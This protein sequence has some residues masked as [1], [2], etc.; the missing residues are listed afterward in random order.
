LIHVGNLKAAKMLNTA[1]LDERSFACSKLR[2]SPDRNFA[3]LFIDNIFSP[4]L[5]MLLQ[6]LP[7]DLCRCKSSLPVIFQI[8]LEFLFSASLCS[9]I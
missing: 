2:S 4:P 6:C 7:F 9:V 8:E 1:R 5:L 3:F